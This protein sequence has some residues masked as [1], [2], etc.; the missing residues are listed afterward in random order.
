MKVIECGNP[1]CDDLK[2]TEKRSISASDIKVIKKDGW[3]W[4]AWC[5]K[6]RVAGNRKYC[7][8]ECR[9]N[10]Y[11]F[12]WPQSEWGLEY[13]LQKQDFKCADCGF[14]WRELLDSMIEEYGRRN[15]VAYNEDGKASSYMFKIFK[16]RC[17]NKYGK[18]RKPE[19]DHI[20]PIKLG[21]EAVGFDNHQILCHTCHKNK[22]KID[23]SNIAKARRDGKSN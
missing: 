23:V 17:E 13:H 9:D 20:V 18:E 22:T 11:A 3:R 8:E 21:G 7:S 19:V 2:K 10:C 12:S 6:E 4:C 1:L 15:I 14:D 5:G 16:G